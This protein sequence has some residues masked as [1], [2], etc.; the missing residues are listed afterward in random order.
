MSISIRLSIIYLP[1]CLSIYLLTFCPP[2]FRFLFAFLW[3]SL[4]SFLFIKKC[5]GFRPRK[6]AEASRKDVLRGRLRKGMLV[7]GTMRDQQVEYEF[8]YPDVA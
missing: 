1:L 4:R 2:E 3:S 6:A 7:R 8:D 5:T